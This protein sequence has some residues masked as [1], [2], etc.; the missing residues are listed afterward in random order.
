M[1]CNCNSINCKSTNCGCKEGGLTTPCAYSQCTGTNVELCAECLC[2]ECVVWCSNSFQI[3]DN[4]GNIFTI[5]KGE[6]L[7]AILQRVGLFL[8]NPTCANS[9]IQ[10]LFE[11]SKTSTTITIGWAG[12]PATT[13]SVNVKYKP[14]GGSWG[15]A[16]GGG[17][18]APTV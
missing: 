11:V 16:T 2:A 15:T 6:R 8:A 7:T 5:A 1:A 10:Y 9:A 17:S 3:E 13:T 4:A 14:V 18:L 12:V